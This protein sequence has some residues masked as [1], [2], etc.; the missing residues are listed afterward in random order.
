[1]VKHL[2]IA[3][4]SLV[5]LSSCTAIKQLN[6]TSNK[7][8]SPAA[9]PAPAKSR[10]I[11][12]I[13]I[14]PE[15]VPQKNEPENNQAKTA[16]VKKVPAA[17]AKPVNQSSIV[18]MQPQAESAN[19]V[20]T[21]RV[22]GPAPVVET[23]SALQFKYALLMDTEVESLPATTLLA[24]VDEWYGVKYRL[25]G[26]TKSGVD[27]SAFTMSVY[28]SVFGMAIPRVSRE[29]YRLSRK[30]STT[31]LKEGDL[32]FFNTRGRGVSH[33]GIYLG[34]NKFIH[35]S[36]SSGVVVSDLFDTYYLRRFIGAGRMEDMPSLTRN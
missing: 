15:T 14:S 22:K 32:V 28:A 21:S 2:F 6:F 26:S 30:I 36:V 4:F 18:S 23:A 35:A 20:S 10:F 31:E 27:C 12:E 16:P 24:A 33:V 19:P 8:V 13:T 9:E 7:Q 3:I 11:E 17:A 1:M 5:A 34:N 25:G 29:Q